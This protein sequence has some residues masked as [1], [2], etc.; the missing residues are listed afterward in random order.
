LHPQPRR[1]HR[2]HLLLRVDPEVDAGGKLEVELRHV[3]LREVH[4]A[5]RG[6]GELGEHLER[7]LEVRVCGR[8]VIVDHRF[9]EPG[10]ECAARR[11]LEQAEA[12]APF[13]DD[14]HPP[15]VEHFEHLEH[16]CARA[17]LVHGTVAG[18][19]DEA[20][21]RVVLDA[22]LDQLAVAGLEDM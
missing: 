14:V 20:K 17:D 16:R 3:R 8:V 18:R 22:F 15:I 13:D 19:E 10:R 11:E 21:V 2:E 9:D 1:N 7:A 4:V 6:L 12:L 5:L